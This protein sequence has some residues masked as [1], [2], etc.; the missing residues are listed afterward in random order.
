MDTENSGLSDAELRERRLAKR[1]EYYAKHAEERRKACR[2]YRK[3]HLEEIKSREKAFYHNVIKKRGKRERLKQKEGE[4]DTEFAKRLEEAKA[5]DRQLH[6]EWKRNNKE[7]IRAY[8]S[9]Y[10]LENKDKIAETHKKYLEDHADEVAAY[11]KKYG[12][13]HHDDIVARRKKQYAARKA[14]QDDAGIPRKTRKH[15]FCK[16]A[17]ER[18]ER[19]KMLR[20]EYAKKYRE[21]YSAKRKA[22]YAEN[23]ERELAVEKIYRMNHRDKIEG[24]RI[25]DRKLAKEEAMDWLASRNEGI[26]EGRELYGVIYLFSNVCTNRFYV[27]QSMCLR[28]RYCKGVE[29][30]IKD[31][32]NVNNACLNQDIEDFGVEAITGPNVLAVA[33]SKE[34]L[35]FLEAHY[36]EVYDSFKNGYNRTNGNIK[37]VARKARR[38]HAHKDAVNGAC[39]HVSN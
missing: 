28:K 19:V 6:N 12:E 23:R 4:T 9:K 25:R 20:R 2:E 27:G 30:F 11:R 38:N 22:K 15:V 5:R 21:R 26:P 29:S 31:K 18:K 7:R 13:E 17:E 33:Y 39:D 16:T 32:K 35:D 14:V 3:A 34:E 10:N 8:Q 1:R 37:S 36:I 24:Y